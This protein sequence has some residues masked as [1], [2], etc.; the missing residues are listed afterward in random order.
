MKGQKMSTIGLVSKQK[1]GRYVGRLSTL[2]VNAP[3][4]IVP[5][6]VD[7]KEL[8]KRDPKKKYP[9][10]AIYVLEK[11]V[12]SGWNKVGEKSGKPFVSCKIETPEIGLLY[13]NLGP[14]AGQDDP[15]VFAL[16]WNAPK[17][18]GLNA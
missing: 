14:A 3:L 12:G 9:N 16:Y 15:D 13:F 6:K 5:V 2:S 1:D 8:E 10:Y 18:Q 11:E 7:K 4:E 17:K